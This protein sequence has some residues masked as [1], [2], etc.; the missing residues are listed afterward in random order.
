MSGRKPHNFTRQWSW[1]IALGLLSILGLLS[2][3]IGEGG[4]WWWLSWAALGTPIVTIAWHMAR[5]DRKGG[6]GHARHRS[7]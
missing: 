6:A 2:A 1:P 7:R 5:A 4:L 3:L